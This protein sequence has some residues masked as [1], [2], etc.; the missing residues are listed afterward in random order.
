MSDMWLENLQELI[1]TR[2]VISGGLG[3]AAGELPKVAEAVLGALRHERDA[4]KADAARLREAIKNR[5]NRDSHGECCETDPCS[6]CELAHGLAA[7]DSAAWLES[8]IAERTA[9]HEARYESLQQQFV[10]ATNDAAR[11]ELRARDLHSAGTG[12]SQR[13]VLHLEGTGPG[14]QNDRKAFDVWHAVA[15][16]APD[17]DE[18]LREV[19]RRALNTANGVGQDTIDEDTESVIDEVL[20]STP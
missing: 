13:L 1:E 5:D 14:P 2:N 16:A 18:R 19:I 17:S 4:A 10:A 12:L 3:I 20:R 8:K 15:D 9:Q 7:T 6:T 11:A